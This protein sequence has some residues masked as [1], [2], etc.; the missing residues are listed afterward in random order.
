MKNY[1]IRLFLLLFT[2][3]APSQEINA[4]RLD[5]YFHVIDSVDNKMLS[6]AIWKDD[7][8]IYDKQIGYAHVE[9][10]KKADKTTKYRIGSIS[11]TFT[12]VLMM[13]AVEENKIK[14]NT[15]LNDF[16]PQFKNADK[17]TIEHMLSH[18]S[19]LFNF[20]N[21]SL[22]F[23]YYTMP[24]TEAEML[25]IM[26]KY[27]PVFEPGAKHEYSNTNYV[28][29]SYIL[30]KIYNKS[31]ADILKQKIITPIHLK[32][33]YFGS[34]IN[35]NKNEAYSYS[36]DIDHWKKM[37]E[38]HPSVPMGAGAIVS[39][40]EDLMIFAKALFN[41]KLITQES[42][43]KMTEGKE[44]Y[45]KG[46][47]LM[48][49]NTH[50]GFGHTGGIDGFSSVFVFFPEENIGAAITSNSSNVNNNEIL[51]TLL[52]A[53]FGK[54]FDLPDLKTYNVQPGDLKKYPGLYSTSLLPLK[55][56]ISIRGNELWAQATGQSAFPLQAKS[57]HIF[58]YPPAGIKIEFIP[59][60]QQ[61]I[62]KQA[63]QKYILTKE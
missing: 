8:L 28:L 4:K 26:A 30:E 11:K 16:Y 34:K 31:Y 14:L 54:P 37:P 32:N 20:T 42:L 56:K 1:L 12:A 2:I 3:Q 17:I 40:P 38:T 5:E 62:L 7:S 51:I 58:V 46:L 48:P 29:L 9:A 53:A 6:V 57:R 59:Q 52:K 55:I 19:G 47:F 23:T 25:E 60:K 35:T 33:T 24:K 50:K 41:N 45:K 13:K 21:D 63:G 43:K 49:F 22:Y 15:P 36:W 44:V 18:Q 27:N 39:T 61:M 10:K